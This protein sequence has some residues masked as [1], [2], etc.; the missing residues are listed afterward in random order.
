MNKLVPYLLL[1]LLASAAQA[2][3]KEEASDPE[4]KKVTER[5]VAVV[6]D[7]WIEYFNNNS[8]TIGSAVLGVLFVL[9]GLGVFSYYYVYAGA[10]GAYDPAVNNAVYQGQPNYMQAYGTNYAT[11]R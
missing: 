3:P 8:W 9:S 6:N 7:G 11:G 2:A 1:L 10:V 5:E 4:E